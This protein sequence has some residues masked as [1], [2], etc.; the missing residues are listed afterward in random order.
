MREVFA[1]AQIRV[2]VATRENLTAA[3]LGAANFTVL[4]DLDVGECSSANISTEQ[5]QLF[6]NQNDVAAT[7]RATE[8]IVYFVN[9]VTWTVNGVPGALNGCASFPAGLPGAAINSSIASRWTLGHEVC[10]VLGLGHISDV[11]EHTGCLATIPECCSTPDVTRL[12]TGC[13]T[14]NIVGT[15]TLSATEITTITGSGLVQPG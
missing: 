9:S 1:T 4:N 3:A 7:R 5:T 6:Q 2:E 11:N 15:P 8:I 14:T 12:M 10:H 13:S